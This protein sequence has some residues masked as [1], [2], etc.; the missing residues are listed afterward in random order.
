M[1][2]IA[3][4]IAPAISVAMARV[5]SRFYFFG[6]LL[7]ASTVYLPHKTAHGVSGLITV[8]IFAAI[9][10]A[11][12][13]LFPW[14]RFVPRTFTLI[15][16]F[17]SS[18]LTALLIYFTGGLQ[19]NYQ[20]LF[21]LIILFSYFHNF[22]EML[23]VTTVVAISYCVPYWYDKPDSYQFAGAAV[24][25][26]FFYLS[27]YLLHG[28]T[29]VML[30][31]NKALEELNKRILDLS[32]LSS[33]LLKDLEE[34]SLIDLFSERLKEH[35][36][37]SFCIVLLLD[38]KRNLITRAV[39]PR[40]HLLWDFSIGRTY[41]ANRLSSVRT[42]LETQEPTIYRIEGEAIDEDLR[43]MITKNTRSMLAVPIF[44]SF[45]NLGIMLFCEERSWD[46][47][48]FTQEKIQLAVAISKQ[49]A[50][51]FR[52]G[53]C[54]DNLTKAKRQIELSHDNI[55]KAERLATLGEVTR[56]VEHEINNPLSVIVNWAEIYR[57]DDTVSPELRKKFQIIY[58]MALRITDVI[59]KLSV[60]KDAK[61]IEFMKGQR[62]TEIK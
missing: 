51:V 45:E 6:I 41:E 60:I 40:R 37:S 29:K 19:S 9:M 25:I 12:L 4:R 46:R 24:T 22:R 55:I 39:C 10:I 16:L 2:L 5:A 27:T 44:N 38:G 36:P 43:S 3:P 26:F 50:M 18:L 48:S 14:N 13:E 47:E 62:M 33:G 42:V 49:L 28:I 61:S 7:V 57:E 54:Y 52:M 31:R 56:A 30:K 23:L 34:G 1:S 58:D 59:Q 20:L 11:V 8:A 53:K 35:V 15:H 17:C 21:F 32:S